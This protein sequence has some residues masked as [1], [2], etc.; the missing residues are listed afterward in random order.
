MVKKKIRRRKR[1]DVRGIRETEERGE[2]KKKSAAI[3]KEE[4]S[5]PL[6][7]KEEE[8]VFLSERF[9]SKWKESLTDF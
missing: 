5:A 7:N 1:P 4:K 3:A 8:K 9:I 2:K 6:E